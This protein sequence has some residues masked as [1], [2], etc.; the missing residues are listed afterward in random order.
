MRRPTPIVADDASNLSLDAYVQNFQSLH[1]AHR[2]A[3][4]IKDLNHLINSAIEHLAHAA[5][6]TEN[7]SAKESIEL[8]LQQLLKVKQ[9]LTID[10]SIPK[11]QIATELQN[12]TIYL[13][14]ISQVL[15][16]IN[17]QGGLSSLNKAI[18]EIHHCETAL[19]DQFF[20]QE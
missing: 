4:H 11:Q 16:V 10:L 6:H 12:I 18:K 9:D 20:T 5:R 8:Q 1:H 19:H 15:H 7:T 3:K 17:D 2:E 13:N 14:D